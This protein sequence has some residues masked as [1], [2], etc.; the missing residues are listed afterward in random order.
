MSRNLEKEYKELM[1]EEMPDLWGRIEAGLEPEQTGT[2]KRNLWKKYGPWGMTAAAACLCLAVTVPFLFNK[3]QS[4]QS[5]FWNTADVL[6]NPSSYNN[7][8]QQGGEGADFD[9]EATSECEGIYNEAQSN[10]TGSF[11]DWNYGDAATEENYGPDYEA[12][13]RMFKIRGRVIEVSEDEGIDVYAVEIEET[14]EGFEAGEIIML[15]DV[16]MLREE[17][18]TGKV[19]QFLFDIVTYSENTPEYWIYDA[20]KN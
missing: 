1:K 15:K 13:E 18:E 4:E 5:N 7:T 11:E 20:I 8:G 3:I 9:G 19:Y 16:G 2:K 10:G 6:S 17:L 14:E 12:D